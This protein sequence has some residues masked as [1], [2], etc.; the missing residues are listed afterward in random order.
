M[1]LN[2]ARSF[3]NKGIVNEYRRPKMGYGAVKDAYEKIAK[4]SK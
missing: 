4:K 3:N 2:R 1:G